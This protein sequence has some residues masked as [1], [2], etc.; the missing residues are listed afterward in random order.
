[1]GKTFNGKSSITG[2]REWIAEAFMPTKAQKARGY[3]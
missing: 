2:T 3:R 1:M